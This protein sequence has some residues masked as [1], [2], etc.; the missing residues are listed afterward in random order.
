MKFVPW[1][2]EKVIGLQASRKED[3]VKGLLVKLSM[4]T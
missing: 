3:E 4:I 2:I 1:E